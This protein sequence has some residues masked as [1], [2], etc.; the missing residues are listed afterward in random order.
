MRNWRWHAV[1]VRGLASS[2]LC[3]IAFACGVLPE[4]ALRDAVQRALTAGDYVEADRLATAWIASVEEQS[5]RDS[6]QSAEALGWLVQARLKNGKA[7]APETLGLAER[8]LRLR[9]HLG[10]QHVDTIAALHYL[11]VTHLLRGEFSDALRAHEQTLA[12]RVASR[13]PD[14]ASVADSLDE[15]GLTLIRLGRLRTRKRG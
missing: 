1:A 3:G 9:E 6:P 10:R 2:V 7:G 14:D 13:G 11:G 4:T 5:G 12:A 15:L 8:A